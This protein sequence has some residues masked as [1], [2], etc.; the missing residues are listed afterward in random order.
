[1]TPLHKAAGLGRYAIAEY[2]IAK[3]PE[4]VSITDTKKRSPLHYAPLAKDDNKTYELLVKSGA[5][6][7]TLDNREKAPGYYKGKFNELESNW[8]YVLPECPRTAKQSFFNEYDWNLLSSSKSDP[9]IKKHIK[10][11]IEKHENDQHKNRSVTTTR[12]RTVSKD[13]MTNGERFRKKSE[14]ADSQDEENS[15][16][17]DNITTTR[18]EHQVHTSSNKTNS[19]EEKENNTG[20]NSKKNKPKSIQKSDSNG[21]DRTNTEEAT[22]NPR[23]KDSAPDTKKITDKQSKTKSLDEGRKSGKGDDKGG[24]KGKH[25]IRENS[26]RS[27]AE[28]HNV[29]TGEKAKQGSPGETSY[30]EMWHPPPPVRAT[31][32]QFIDMERASSSDK[33]VSKTDENEQDK[34]T[35]SNEQQNKSDTNYTVSYVEGSGEGVIEGVVNGENEVESVNEEGSGHITEQGQNSN[36]VNQ[37]IHSDNMERLAALVLNGNGNWLIGH[38]SPNPEIQA[39]LD[40]VPVYMSKIHRI[41][42]AARNGSLKDLQAALDRRKFAIAKDNISPNGATALHVAVLFG[43]TSIV[44]YLAG[45]FPETVN[46]TDDNGRTP[47]HFA[48]TL[49]DNGHYYNLLVHLGADHTIK[50]NNGFT[51]EYYKTK[52]SELSHRMLLTDYGGEELADEILKDKDKSNNSQVDMPFFWTEEG[53]YLASSLGDPLIKGLTE[54]ANKRP[55]DPI[56]YLASYLSNFSKVDD[57]NCN[58]T[59]N[60][61]ANVSQNGNDKTSTSSGRNESLKRE[62]SSTSKHIDVVTLD[63]NANNPEIAEEV[64]TAFNSTTR[65]EHGQSMLHFAAARSHNRNALFQLLQETNINVGYRDELYRTARDISIQADITENTQEIDKYVFY[66]ACEGDT[67]KLVELLLEGYD[68]IIDIMD[69]ANVPIIEA[70]SQENQPE[71]VAFL[72]SI[73]TFEEKRERVHYAIRRGNLNEIKDMLADENETG[74]GR[75]LAVCKNNY[76]RCTLHIAVLCQQE[77][78]IEYLATQFSEC[79][80]IGDN[81]ERTALHYAMGIEKIESISGILIKAGAKRVVKDLKGRQ[82]TYYFM[83][84]SDILRLQEEE[85]MF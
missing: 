73:L 15:Q 32:Q 62:K 67:D 20:V 5:D 66:I 84:K 26:Q 54:I 76:G 27:P 35:E 38:K 48:A 51:P 71:T 30:E 52:R 61:S 37:L 68:H 6:E 11:D 72:Q 57:D 13:K 77:E 9:E 64:K 41:H 74:S 22:E 82:P 47:L 31:S 81:L 40:N 23:N 78:I 2:I 80:S 21:K 4:S 50:D 42:S 36:V 49:D 39:F 60:N 34:K 28:E 14:Q 29:K 43:N 8:L 63:P 1:M 56:A 46:T 58:S 44:R 7:Y 65:D 10:T 16:E 75:L 24:D 53:R 59:P 79:L 17:D 85:E 55:E 45:R 25:L 83:N 18:E 3:Y 33:N 19:Q 70:V 12:K 69:D